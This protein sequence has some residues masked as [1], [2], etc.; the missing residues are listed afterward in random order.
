M[1]QNGKSFKKKKFLQH[2][3]LL[4]R[5]WYMLQTRHRKKAHIKTRKHNTPSFRFHL[6]TDETTYTVDVNHEPDSTVNDTN[7]ST[8]MVATADVGEGRY[9]KGDPLNGYYDF[10][11]N[12]GSYK[13][14]AVF[15]VSWWRKPP[16]KNMYIT[17]DAIAARNSGVLKLH[18]KAFIYFS[19]IYLP[20]DRIR[21]SSVGI[22]RKKKMRTNTNQ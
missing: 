9:I 14:W 12:E 4:C 3:V 18:I 11:I 7:N 10:L 20:H 2:I 6:I 19:S 1:K 22:R 16:L 5:K 13:F 15:Q 8:A 17:S 21:P